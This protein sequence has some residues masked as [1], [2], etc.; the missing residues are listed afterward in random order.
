MVSDVLAAA[1]GRQSAPPILCAMFDTELFG[2]WWFEGPRF[3]GDVIDV[4]AAAGI[5][6]TSA[7]THLERHP[8]NELV[9]LPEG[10]W[11]DGGRHE[12]WLNEATRWT[13]GPVHAAEAR[14]ERLVGSGAGQSE[15][16]FDRLMRQ[17]GRELLLLEASDWQFLITTFAARDYAERRLSDHASDFGRLAELAERRLAGGA[18]SQA[19]EQFLSECEGRDSLFAEFDWRERPASRLAS[20]APV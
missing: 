12:V 1:A 9:D 14:F 17:A 13:W 5:E 2:H 16:L 3:L 15:P 18:L 8:S 6:L 4:A 20:A 11:G 19:D 10:S 7:G